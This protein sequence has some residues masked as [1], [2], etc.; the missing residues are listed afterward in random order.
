VFNSISVIVSRAVLGAVLFLAAA[1]SAAVAQSLAPDPAASPP[2][3]RQWFEIS[4][5]ADGAG[6]SWSSYSTATAA[7]LSSI[8]ENGYRLRIGGGY[9]HY[10][11]TRPV[12]DP[13]SRRH[14]WPEFFGEQVWGDV[15]IGYQWTIGSTS[16][17]AFLGMT[18]EDHNLSPGP[19]SPLDFDDE[20]AIQ[21]TRRGTKVVLETWTRLADWGFLQVDA[22]WSEPF[23]AYGGRVRL[24][25]FLADGWS[26]GIEGSAFGNLNYDGGRAGAF[27]RYDWG[28]GEVSLSGGFDG[29]RDHVGSGY[30][31]VGM[32][33][34]F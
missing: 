6:S 4:A 28:S 30:V 23:E 11:Y 13:V 1:S 18:Q 9:G 20:N 7:L 16:L 15:L 5:G 12:F 21:G 24:G 22:N 29:N 34:R 33:T 25:H 8:N 26:A 31:S 2:L 10:R 27:A 17:K 19:A 14:L 3:A 32:T